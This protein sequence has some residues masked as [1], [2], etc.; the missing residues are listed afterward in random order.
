MNKIFKVIWSKSKQCYIVVSELA[1]NTTGK[2]KIVVAGILAS[3]AVSI[4]LQDVSATSGT[5]NRAG[6]THIQSG[7]SFS[8]T[9]GIVLGPSMG[10]DTPIAKV[11]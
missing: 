9:E 6:W 7:T 8:P 5:G 3:L 11:M 10:G 4:P 2:K 1:K